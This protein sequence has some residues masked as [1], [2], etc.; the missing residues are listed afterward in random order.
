MPQKFNKPA[1]LIVQTV[2][3]C[4][5]I[6]LAFFINQDSSYSAYVVQFIGLLV[7]FYFVNYFANRNRSGTFSK[8]TDSV[9][10]VLVTLLVVLETGGLQS[11]ALFLIFI[12]VTFISLII[13]PAA[14]II[15]ITL[16]SLLLE[17]DATLKGISTNSFQFYLWL[18]IPV[19]ISYISK[20]YV[21]L[22]ENEQK[23][24]IIETEE[25]ILR[26][27]VQNIEDDVSS[28]S[29][30]SLIILADL[31]GSVG[32]LIQGEYKDNTA[33]IKISKDIKDLQENIKEIPDLVEEKA[34]K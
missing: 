27:E 15:T 13:N 9:I 8:M 23:I 22:L 20:Q 1:L 12:L 4:L 25:K 17:R 30:R 6:L 19:I 26:E 32:N 16:I 2:F 31:S 28:F 5:S 21:K 10:L 11:P 3:L 33:L 18:T 7:I 24:Q 14:A 34:G 29:K